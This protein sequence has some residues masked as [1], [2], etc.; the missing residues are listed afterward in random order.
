MLHFQCFEKF[1]NFKLQT[2]MPFVIFFTIFSN[3][4]LKNIQ[5]NEYKKWRLHKIDWKKRELV[6]E[7]NDVT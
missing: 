3:L 4:R 5:I 1:L 7:T 6:F 2:S